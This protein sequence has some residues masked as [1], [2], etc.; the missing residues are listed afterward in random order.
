V[1]SHNNETPLML[2]TGKEDGVIY[3]ECCTTIVAKIS[4]LKQFR[5]GEEPVTSPVDV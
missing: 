2:V 3:E 1:Q 4:L 5:I